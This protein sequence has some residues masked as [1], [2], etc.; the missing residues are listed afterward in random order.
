[1]NILANQV[2]KIEFKNFIAILSS[3][4]CQI[5]RILENNGPMTRNEIVKDLKTARTT[6][7][8]NLV[9]LERLEIIFK[10]SINNGMIGRPMV[11]WQLT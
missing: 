8:D 5:I 10:N 11:Y 4:Q 9:K 6:I 1:M 3:L 2:A 7:Y